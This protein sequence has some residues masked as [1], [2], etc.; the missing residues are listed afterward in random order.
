M[1]NKETVLDLLGQIIEEAEKENLHRKQEAYEEG[2]LERTAGE[3]WMLF[4]LKA[5]K[6]LLNKK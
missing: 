6:E 1:K 4:H 5:L 3:S 2:D